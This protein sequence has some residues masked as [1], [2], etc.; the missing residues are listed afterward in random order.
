MLLAAC[1]T[2][3]SIVLTHYTV[4]TCAGQNGLLHSSV[5]VI[6]CAVLIGDKSVTTSYTH[7]HTPLTALFPGLPG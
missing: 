6:A 5:M 7:T 1:V 3:G 2:I 4:P